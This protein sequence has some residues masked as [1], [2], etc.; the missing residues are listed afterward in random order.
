MMI[1]IEPQPGSSYYS[2]TITD[3]EGNFVNT[4]EGALR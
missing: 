4:L 2:A 3:D 1:W